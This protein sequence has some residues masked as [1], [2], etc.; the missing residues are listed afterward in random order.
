MQIDRQIL[1]KVFLP[2]FENKSEGDEISLVE[3]NE[4]YDYKERCGALTKEEAEY[5]INTQI[6]MGRLVT[7]SPPSFKIS[8]QTSAGTHY[9]ITQEEVSKA[10]KTYSEEFWKKYRKLKNA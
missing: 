2:F 1:D 4:L 3:L 7:V 5:V 9:V 6:S 8:A 10:A